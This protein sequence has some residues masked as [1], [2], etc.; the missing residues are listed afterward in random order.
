MEGPRIVGFG[1]YAQKGEDS[2]EIEEVRSRDDINFVDRHLEPFPTL[3]GKYVVLETNRSNYGRYLGMT[4][5]ASFVLDNWV[6]PVK[7]YSLNLN[8]VVVGAE[9]VEEPAYI[10]GPVNEIKPFSREGIERLVEQVN[11]FGNNSGK[12]SE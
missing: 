10:G 4:G 3:V 11:T 8:G 2:W 6:N 9:I 1:T 7:D 5:S 12:D